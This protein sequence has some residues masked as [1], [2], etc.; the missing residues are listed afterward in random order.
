MPKPIV[1]AVVGLSSGR[2][3]LCS[4]FKKRPQHYQIKWL[5]NQS[6]EKK[7]AEAV[8]EFGGKGTQNFDDILNDPEVEL[9]C[10]ATKL[11]SHVPLALRALKA[12]KHVLVEKPMAVSIE[13]ADELVTAAKASGKIVCVGHQR[14]FNADQKAVAE[15]LEK[16]SLGKILSVRVELPCTNIDGRALP[17]DPK[18]WNTRFTHT[19]GYDYLVH[20]VDQICYLLKEK[21]TRIFGRHQTLEN[22]DLPAAIEITLFLPSGILASVIMRYSHALDLKWTIDGEKGSLRMQHANEMGTC[23][24]YH[25]QPDESRI[26]R[27]IGRSCTYDDSFVELHDRLYQAIRNGSPVPA[28]VE[29]GR[30]AV[31]I[32]WRALES[33]RNG[34]I[35]PF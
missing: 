31:K 17:S 6:N 19:P 20:L 1:S 8:A 27:E 9:V 30:D 11:E 28:P 23:L 14:R 29:D 5:C 12:G 24:V 32:I 26:V 15:V 16:G 3:L 35:I 25:F 4:P 13:E 21:P 10:I 18:T 34:E 2:Y 33:A 22:N 7:L